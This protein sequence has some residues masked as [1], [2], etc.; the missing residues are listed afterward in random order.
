MNQVSLTNHERRIIM[1]LW[2]TYCLHEYIPNE[3]GYRKKRLMRQRKIWIND[4]HFLKRTQ[5]KNAIMH[6]IERN[7][8]QAHPIMGYTFSIREEYLHKIYNLADAGNWDLLEKLAELW[9]DA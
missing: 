9:V 5:H 7:I 4:V 3:K 8:I 6:L 2:Q 1:D